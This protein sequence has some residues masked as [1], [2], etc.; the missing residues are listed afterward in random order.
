MRQPRIDRKRQMI[1]RPGDKSGENPYAAP[2]EL[3]P[4]AAG[5]LPFTYTLMKL[6]GVK[7]PSPYTVQ[8]RK[9]MSDTAEILRSV[10]IKQMRAKK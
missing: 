10:A 5:I 9:K 4:E 2:G 8:Q 3:N 1:P 6:A 7:G